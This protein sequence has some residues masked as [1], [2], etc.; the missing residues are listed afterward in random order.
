M[1]DIKP[2]SLPL[3]KRLPSH[4]RAAANDLRVKMMDVLLGHPAGHDAGVMF[5]VSAELAI[6]ALRRQFDGNKARD[7]WINAFDFEREVEAK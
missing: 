3:I 5:A 7:V 4:Q 2:L 1:A 6:F